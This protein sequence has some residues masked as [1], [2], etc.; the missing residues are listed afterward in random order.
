MSG[1]SALTAAM[2]V[3]GLPLLL[4]L[5]L[6]RYDVQVTAL[7]VISLLTLPRSTRAWTNG[8]NPN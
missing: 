8:W 7:A 1:S 2:W 5:P 4:H 6:A 3:G